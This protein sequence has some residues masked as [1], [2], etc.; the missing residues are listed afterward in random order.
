MVY[1]TAREQFCDNRAA[2]AGSATQV[3]PSWLIILFLLF[4]LWN[5]CILIYYFSHDSRALKN[6]MISK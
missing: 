2:R 1:V 4:K 3:R 6:L 5:D